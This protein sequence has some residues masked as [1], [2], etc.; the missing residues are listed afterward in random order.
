LFVYRQKK[1]NA[2]EAFKDHSEAIANTVAIAERCNLELQL[3]KV[4]LPYFDVPDNKSADKYLYE[5]CTKGLSSRYPGKEQDAIIQERLNYELSV[6]KKTGFAAYFLIVQDFVN[7]AKQNGIV[8]GP[9]RGSAAGSIVS[10]LI[11]ITNIDPLK[12]ELI[13]ER[14]LNPER[15][16]MPD[17]D[18]DFA[19]TRRDEVINYVE[20]KYGKDHV[21]QIITFG[22]MAARAA[23]RDTGRVLDF[24]YSYCDKIAKL[25]PMFTSIKDALTANPEL[26]AVYQNE[27]DAKQLLDAAAKLE[28]V[29]RH[30]STHACGVVI[31][32]DSLDH[33]VPCQ[34]PAQGDNQTV[35]SQYD[36]HAVEDLGLLKMDFL[37]L[38][39]LTI[40]E[41]TINIIKKRR[42]EEINI[43]TIPLDDQKT[44][45]LLQQGKTTGVFQLESSG[46]K[47]YRKQLKPTEFEDIIAMVALYRPD[48]MEY[49]PDFIAGKHGRKQSTYLH[50]KLKPILQK[51]YGVA[52]YQEQLMKIARDL[53]GFSMSEADT[54]RKAVGKKIKRLLEQQRDKLIHGMIKNGIT[55]SI[56]T[57]IWKLVEPFA[58]Y[59]FVRA[60]AA[61]YAMI[62][63]QTAYFKANY[64]DE[65]MASLLTSD[66][67][68]IDR[69]AIEVEECEQMGIQVLPPDINESFSTFTAVVNPETQKPEQK[70]RFG[71]LAIKNVGFNIAKTII[72]ER[73]ENGTYKSLEDFLSRARTKDLNKKSLESLIKSGALDVF[74]ERNQLLDNIDSLLSYA[75]SA[76]KEALNGQTNLF[77]VLPTQHAP[78]LRLKETTKAPK[79]Q[80]LIWEK[81]LLGLYISEHPLQEYSHH[82]KSIATPIAELHSQMHS[83]QEVNVG[84]I[85]TNIQ[86]VIT[87]NNQPMLFVK[88]EDMS[89]RI[90]AL[91]FPKT[92]QTNPSIWEEEKV[93]LI[94]GRISDKDGA[95]KLLCS[96][97]KAIDLAMLDSNGTQPDN[98]EI[99]GVSITIPVDTNQHTYERL[100][101]ILT[102]YPGSLQVHLKVRSRQTVK[103]ITTQFSVS[104]GCFNDIE[105]L[106][107]SNSIRLQK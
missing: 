38:K 64:P 5:L 14:F 15:I 101:E 107:G 25:I 92:L 91:V 13:F 56:A 74:G 86:K 79:N 44:F 9:G 7:W 45:K 27:T 18:L 81:E 36:L 24:P 52:V 99:R 55:K 84:G 12:Y 34:Y 10:Y 37:G 96:E 41:N 60:H 105:Q 62:A 87:R 29:A 77:G 6:I 76:E 42:G 47:R 22:T 33:Y 17:I 88:I 95:I 51:T 82:L 73:K 65:F 23:V 63:Y 58:N 19:D 16:S 50:P 69:I 70:I 39:N 75:K 93:V 90:E 104:K 103:V 32:K 57:K 53:A 1:R 66:Y 40:L 31:T 3:G 43:N 2:K 48:P 78:H 49:I 11:N 28:G 97:A 106:I 83:G 8:V 72:R 61:C 102:E 35:V 46:M 54:L 21:A 59:G 26:K 89:G 4:M 98:D 30:A 80:R 94:Q 20:K 71:L 68:D 100:K 67:G 85:I